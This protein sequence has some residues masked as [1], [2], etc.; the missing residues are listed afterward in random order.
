MIFHTFIFF[1]RYFLLFENSS[2]AA[3]LHC[4]SDHTL[5]WYFLSLNPGVLSSRS[6]RREDCSC[7]RYSRVPDSLL[8]PRH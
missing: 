5:R 8:H 4:E 1:S 2:E 7:H 6:V 3:V